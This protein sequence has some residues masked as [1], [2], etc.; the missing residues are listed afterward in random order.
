MSRIFE[1]SVV[2]LVD[3][4]RDERLNAALA[5]FT[6]SGVEIRM[7]KRL[8][9]LRALSAA[10]NLED[11]KESVL[12]IVALD[13]FARSSGRIRTQ[14]RLEAL[15]QLTY[16]D[17]STV[18]RFE[19]ASTASYEARI[20]ELLKT[21]VEPEPAPLRASEKRTRLMTNLKLKLRNERVLA[22]KGEDISDHRVLMNVGIAEGLSADFLLKNGA[23]HVI[24]TVDASDENASPRKIVVDIALSAL[25]LEQARMTF[26]E[27]S[28][29]SRLVY[30]ASP[31]VEKFAFPSLD[32]AAHQG[33]NLVNWASEVD[34][35]KLIDDLLSLA[36]PYEEP[37]KRRMPK[38]HAGTQ[39]K[40]EIN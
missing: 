28:T 21:L 34:R 23:M 12:H 25:V 32:A 33:A 2:R 9:K 7:P 24:E 26:G 36:I 3:Q 31:A 10:L 38:I 1:Y 11:V 19:A 15:R 4:C 30:E 20:S 40:F 27:D 16:L 8:E 6:E 37:S 39:H 29:S 35:K 13:E 17:F 18:E 5:I 22:R 14:A